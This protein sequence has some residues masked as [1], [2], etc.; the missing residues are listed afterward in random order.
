MCTTYFSLQLKV[1]FRNTLFNRLGDTVRLHN[2]KFH[3]YNLKRE[4][5]VPFEQYVAKFNVHNTF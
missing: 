5:N 3:L 2:V 4:N 1:K